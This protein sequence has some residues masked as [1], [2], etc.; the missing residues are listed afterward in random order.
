LGFGERIGKLA[1]STADD[2]WSDIV[3]W[4]RIE[5]NRSIFLLIDTALAEGTAT[6]TMG[7]GLASAAA[8]RSAYQDQSQQGYRADVHRIF[9]QRL[10][11][12]ERPDVALA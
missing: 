1:R 5:D 10:M 9:L 6:P 2:W 7:T 3:E 4:I 11:T 12:I 8:K